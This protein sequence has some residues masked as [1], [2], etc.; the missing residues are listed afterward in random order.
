MKYSITQEIDGDFVVDE[1]EDPVAPLFCATYRCNSPYRNQDNYQIDSWSDPVTIRTQ[2]IEH[3]YEYMAKE[4]VDHTLASESRAR[5]ERI[6]IED[7]KI[8][9]SN[10]FIEVEHYNEE[11]LRNSITYK[12]LG[13]ERDKRISE[14]KELEKRRL[15][16]ARLAEI[17]WREEQD[18]K[19]YT[20]LS[21]KFGPKS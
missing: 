21:K 1:L 11:K 6:D 16:A 5:D 15:E 2:T 7:Y 4:R 18:K 10:I 14:K 12:N 20:R 9:F 19:E 8:E 3:L 17:K 13:A